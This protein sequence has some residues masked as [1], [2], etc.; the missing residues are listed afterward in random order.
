V[1]TKFRID[2][3]SISCPDPQAGIWAPLSPP[4]QSLTGRQ[5]YQ[6]GYRVTLTWELMSDDD[7]GDLMSAWLDT[8]GNGFCITSA[9]VPPYRS[10]DNSDWDTI[11]GV[12]GG[13]ITWLEP[14]CQVREVL[15]ATGVTLVLEGVAR[16]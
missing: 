13:Y 3:D 7:Y 16:P 12:T 9:V 4:A 5:V 10:Q 6:G 15:Q 1:A 2:G 8:E 11:H 14:Q